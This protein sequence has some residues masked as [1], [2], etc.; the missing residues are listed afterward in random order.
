[1]ADK[2]ISFPSPVEPLMKNRWLLTVGKIPHY[3]IRNVNLDSFTDEGKTYTKLTFSIFNIIGYTVVP[4]DVVG[5]NKIKLEFLDPV[6]TV[7]NGYD[8]KVKF[9]KMNL[10][11][12]YG[13]SGLLEHNF[14]FYV[15]N[16]N[17]LYTNTGE[18]SEKEIIE[19]YKNKKEVT[20]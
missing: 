14:E 11:C 15:K 8:M 19:N 17:Q 20:S 1:M 9:E 12:D 10:N 6:G 13:S 16:L 5:L 18:L 7:V 4:D 3:L 2:F